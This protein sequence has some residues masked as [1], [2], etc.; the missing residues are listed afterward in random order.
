MNLNNLL[1]RASEAAVKAGHLIESSKDAAVF[2][3]E[4]GDNLASQIVTQ[5]DIAS[6]KLIIEHLTPSLEEYNLGLLSEE[7]TLP[8]WQE[9]RFLK[10]YF[11]CIDP[12][13]GT[14]PFSQGKHGY[15]VSIALVTKEGEPLIGVVYDPHRKNLYS[16][17]KGEGSL[18]NGKTFLVKSSESQK[19]NIKNSGPAVMNALQTIEEAPALY[20]KEPHLEKRGGSLWD[21]AATSLIQREAGGFNSDFKGRP[22]DLNRK[23]STYM[24]HR[25]IIFASDPSLILHLEDLI[26]EHQS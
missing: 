18:R 6:E 19:V 7:G 26:K 20:Y 23:D 21:F 22:L 2:S 4:G 25:G 16:A 14:L 9:S 17:L 1:E 15:A 8:H 11:W 12:L 10:E 13:D 5:A 3:K 24:N